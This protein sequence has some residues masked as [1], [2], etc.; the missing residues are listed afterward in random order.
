MAALISFELVGAWWL[1]YEWM[2]YEWMGAK[3]NEDAWLV[4][5]FDLTPFV[6]LFMLLGLVASGYCL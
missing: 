5:E 2:G 6:R 4:D 1:G 3:V